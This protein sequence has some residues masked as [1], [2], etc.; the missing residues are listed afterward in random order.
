MYCALDKLSNENDEKSFVIN[1]YSTSAIFK[2]EI[3][4]LFKLNK[5]SK[6][7]IFAQF[8]VTRLKICF[9]FECRLIVE[10]SF[11]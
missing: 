6:N 3:L 2:A 11:V 10:Y 4:R 9:C 5:L 1:L 8:T 7:D